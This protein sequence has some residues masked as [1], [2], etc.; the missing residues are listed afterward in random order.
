MDEFAKVLDAFPVFLGLSGLLLSIILVITNKFEKGLTVKVIGTLLVLLIALSADNGFVFALSVFVIATLVTDLEFLEKL[1][2]IAWNRK[3][4]W[5][6][7]LKDASAAEVRQKLANN[8]ELEVSAVP[9]EVKEKGARNEPTESKSVRGEISNPSEGQGV[10]SIRKAGVGK[11]ISDAL[12]FYEKAR[13][14]I[15]ELVLPVKIQEVIF[16]KT[17]IHS[18]R[19]RIIDFVIITENEV[20][21]FE[22]KNLKTKSGLM[23]AV[24]Q[25]RSIKNTFGPYLHVRYKNRIIKLVII[26]PSSIDVP[27]QINGAFI[28]KFDA[29]R[30]LFTNVEQFLADF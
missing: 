14:A 29:D 17:I 13:S 4:Y 7:K 6:F 16:E 28:L 25:A 3:E 15:L 22:A 5:D 24:D 23:R 30:S 27:D 8:S 9:N 2:A 11:N 10:Y 19:R 12:S 1:A 20:V 21:I 18:G 26:V